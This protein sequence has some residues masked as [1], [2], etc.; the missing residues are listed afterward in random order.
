VSSGSEA[1]YSY[2][3]VAGGV[4]V[5]PVLG[6]RSRDTLTGIGPAQLAAGDVVLIGRGPVGERVERQA[7]VASSQSLLL[8]PGPHLDRFPAGAFDQLLQGGEWTVGPRSDRTALRLD[9]PPVVPS[10]HDLPSEGLV[11]G[12]V[13]VPP[14]GQPILFLAN[15]PTTGGYPLIG[16]V[17]ADD[18]GRAAQLRPGRS[19]RFRAS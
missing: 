17:A 18:V 6:S 11:P 9:G 13:Q 7:V 8:L 4:D 14:D 16:V 5:P 2:L 15:H 3:A 10:R 1:V 12:A 19:L